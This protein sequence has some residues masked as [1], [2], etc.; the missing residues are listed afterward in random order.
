M[1]RP[2]KL[3]TARTAKKTDKCPWCNE[4]IACPDC[5]DKPDTRIT[6]ALGRDW[7]QPCAL[8]CSPENP[9]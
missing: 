4:P 1:P 8:A 6:D 5:G 7:H 3:L 9:Q 2:G